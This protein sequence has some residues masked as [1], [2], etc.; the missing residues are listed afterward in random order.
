MMKLW[1]GWSGVPIPAGE[2]VFPQNISP[3][4]K[5]IHPPIQWVPDAVTPRGWQRD[6]LQHDV[7]HSMCLAISVLCPSGLHFMDLTG[8]LS[9][10]QEA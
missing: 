9:T 6:C 4:L 5:P 7:D 1:A 10:V 3:F 2:I 8:L